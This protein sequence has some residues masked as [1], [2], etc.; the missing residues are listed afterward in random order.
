MLNFLPPLLKLRFQLSQ[1]K[2]RYQTGRARRCVFPMEYQGV[3]EDLFYA[4]TKCQPS[5]ETAYALS[6]PCH[7]II[8]Q[9]DGVIC[10][11]GF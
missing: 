6:V 11:D 8:N 3:E 4:K 1:P 10:G 5:S 9:M 7:L 2:A